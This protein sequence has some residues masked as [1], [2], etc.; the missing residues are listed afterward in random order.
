MLNVRSYPLNVVLFLSEPLGRGVF[1]RPEEEKGLMKEND[2]RE[3]R[4]KHQQALKKLRE[5]GV[6]SGRQD[7]GRFH[8]RIHWWSQT[9]F[10]SCSRDGDYG[11]N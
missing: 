10:H 9:E 4:T 5:S 11:A 3:S 6:A 7:R 1:E 8:I 2:R